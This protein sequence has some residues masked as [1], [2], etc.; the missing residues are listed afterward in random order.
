[1]R[2]IELV[3]NIIY[4]FIF[5]LY[6]RIFLFFGKISPYFSIETIKNSRAVSFM[7]IL[8]LFISFSIFCILVGLHK[9]YLPN[10]FLYILIAFSV[11][12]TYYLILY[13]NKCLIYFKEFEAKPKQWKTKWG[14]ISLGIIIAIILL[15]IISFK[16]MNY[17]LH[18][19]M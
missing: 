2:H 19:V 15:L 13:K 12:F 18:G 9:S 3:W 7:F 10:I 16:I 17:S 8:N 14:W 5:K 6:D 11:L 4:Y 1:M